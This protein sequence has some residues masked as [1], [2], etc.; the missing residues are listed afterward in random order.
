[1]IDYRE[2]LRLQDLRY[3]QRGIASMVQSLRNTVSA[4][5]AAARAAGV[6]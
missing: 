2:I 1:M 5:I 4:V 6:S 3:S